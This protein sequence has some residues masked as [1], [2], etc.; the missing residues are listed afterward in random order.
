MK[1]QEI[2]NKLALY[3]DNELS[4][5]E[6]AE[7][8]QHLST[9]SACVREL[10]VIKSI[11]A[12]AQVETFAEPEPEYW[13]Q[14]RQNVMQQIAQPQTKESWMSE[15]LAQIKKVIWHKKISYRLVSLAVTAAIVF[16]I[17]RISFMHD[18][19]FEALVE[20]SMKDP[21]EILASKKT[22]IPEQPAIG[23]GQQI[24]E[25]KSQPKTAPLFTEKD[26]ALPKAQKSVST[27]EISSTVILKKNQSLAASTEP[28]VIAPEKESDIPPAPVAVLTETD[29]IE[30]ER[31]PDRAQSKK[32][33]D[34]AKFE[35][36]HFQLS[37]VSEKIIKSEADSSWGQFNKIRQQAETISEIIQKIDIWEKYL[38]ANPE[39]KFVQ[40]ATYELALLY[41]DLANDNPTQDNI[42]KALIFYSENSQLLFSAP[43][44]L[45]FKKQFEAL[46]ALEKK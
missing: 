14:L 31:F 33:L 23:S 26:V 24:P 32:I 8:E 12:I 2:Q 29:K 35:K 43:D 21:T 46:Q 9:C 36:A 30:G 10:E 19:K 22:T 25:T 39:I 40:M 37:T 20:I 6:S 17:V 4:D 11:D 34:R 28:V 15:K 16:F 1:C 45:K 18:E 3:L 7:I 27:S 38:Q 44:S 42:H 41:F 13:N 5:Q